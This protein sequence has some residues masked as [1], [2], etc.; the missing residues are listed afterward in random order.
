MMGKMEVKKEGVMAEARKETETVAE[1]R[2]EAGATEAGRV[3]TAKPKMRKGARNLVLLGIGATAIAIITTSVSLAI[4]HNSGDIYIDRSRPGFLPEEEELE[5][6]ETE[7]EFEMD[8]SGKMSE[9]VLTE[10]LENLDAE[11]KA[12]DAYENPFS[13]EALSDERLGIPTGE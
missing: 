11:V 10:Y 5:K 2:K 13:S 12:I 1:T 6:E 4:Y 7:V 8:K 9:E 3:E